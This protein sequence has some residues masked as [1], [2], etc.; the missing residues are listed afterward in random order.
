MRTPQQATDTGWEV[1]EGTQG[2][3]H[4][5]SAIISNVLRLEVWLE[6][7]QYS[8]LVYVQL[9]DCVRN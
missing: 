9:A 1:H 3:E 8:C 5:I 6:S 2:S 4:S 7:R